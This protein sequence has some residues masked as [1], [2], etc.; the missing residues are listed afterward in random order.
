M[1]YLAL[2]ADYDGTLAVNGRISDA[3]AQAI[4]RLRIS[5]RRA[6]L[7]TGRRL[8]DLLAVCPCIQL[9][10]YVV[11]EN[12]AL[13]CDPKGRGEIALAKPPPEHFVR[14]LQRRGVEPLE[15]GKVIVATRQPHGT[16]VLEVIQELGLELQIICNRAAVMVLPTGVNKVTGLEYALRKLGLSLHE[17][18]GI[19]DAANDLSFLERC[20]CAVA[21]ANAIPSVQQAAAFVTEGEAGDGVRQLID[22]LIANDLHRMEGKL[23]QNLILLG[24]GADGAAVAIPPY[25]R[26]ILIAGPSGSG[27]STFVTGF[28]ERLID[29]AYQVCVVDPEGDYGTLQDLAALGS[30]QRAPTVNEVLSLL[31]DPRINLSVNLLGIALMDRPH[32]F[33]QLMPNLQAMRARTGRP[34]W[35]VLDEA[36]HMLP[37]TRGQTPLTLPQRLGETVMVTVH[38]EHVAPLVLSMIDVAVAVGRTPERTLRKFSAAS[39]RAL[40]WPQ[41]L[42]HRTG[43]AVAWLD[44]EGEMP[45]SMGPVPGRAERI[46]HHRKYAE[47]DLRWHS[48]YFRGPDNRHNLRAQNLAI[49]CQIAEGIDE[50]TWL[51]HLCRGDYSRWCRGAIKDDYLADEVE[52]I[53]RRGDLAPWQT[54]QLVKALIEARYT[55]PE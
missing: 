38:P 13:V 33:A 25:G 9:F 5:G 14:H 1:R 32:F 36:H 19:G 37:G 3:T 10:D 39:G 23:R 4:E 8:D 46:R 6:I 34:H 22:E 15:K 12:G 30:P 49:F 35:L 17:V 55:L 48:F 43:R 54:R 2:A 29:Q 11:A 16:A 28:V 7:L 47:G 44:G 50:E 26:N 53:E 52:R 24:H 45:F 21:V 41:G 31:E 40:S 18:V 42:G 51:F 20:E 27:K